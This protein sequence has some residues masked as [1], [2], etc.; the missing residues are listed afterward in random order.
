LK[1]LLVR[2]KCFGS[3][4]PKTLENLDIWDCDRYG[5]CDPRDYNT[6]D[7]SGCNDLV[8]VC[9]HKTKIKDLNFLY[10]CRGINSLIVSDVEYLN[11]EPLK[12]CTNLREFMIV[13]KN[14]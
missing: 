14:D 2:M 8:S 4:V 13:S 1:V 6:L 3:K 7:L 12:M 11:T 5:D 9:L 10:E